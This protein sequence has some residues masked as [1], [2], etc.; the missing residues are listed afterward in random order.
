MSNCVLTKDRAVGAFRQADREE[1][2]YQ[3]R[4]G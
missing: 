3:L 2:C 1:G 4:W